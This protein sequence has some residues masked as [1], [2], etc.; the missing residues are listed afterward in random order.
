MQQRNT[1]PYYQT[2]PVSGG[3]PQHQ[4]YSEENEEAEEEEEGGEEDEDEEGLDD[5]FDD[6]EGPDNIDDTQ[7]IGSSLGGGVPHGRDGHHQ[8][9]PGSYGGQ[10]ASA[11]LADEAEGGYA[12]AGGAQ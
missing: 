11:L 9:N 2:E 3:H 7:G 6:D 1:R 12:G 8:P 5:E 10:T 4:Q